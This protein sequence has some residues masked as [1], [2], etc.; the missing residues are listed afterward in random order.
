L[1][2]WLACWAAIGSPLMNAFRDSVGAF[3]PLAYSRFFVLTVVALLVAR[4]YLHRFQIIPAVC[5][6]ML[7]GGVAA[8][9]ASHEESWP[10]VMEARGYSVMKPHFCGVDL[11]WLAPTSDGRGLEKHGAGKDCGVESRSASGRAVVESRFAEGSYNLYL[12]GVAA[13][14]PTRITFSDANEIDP[15][16]TPDGCGIVF[17]SDQGRGLGSTALYRLDASRFIAGCGGD[18]PAADPRGSPPRS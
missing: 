17:A 7:A 15:T 5:L 12:A 8:G 3:T 4:L 13:G 10:R 16:F 11:R 1:Y 2:V 6:G 9:S 18:A 14:G